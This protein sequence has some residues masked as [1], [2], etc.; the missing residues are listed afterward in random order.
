VESNYVDFATIMIYLFWFFFFGLIVY[1]RME[2]KRE[3]YPLV[4]DRKSVMV[5]GWPA[6]PAPKEERAKHSAL[7]IWEARNAAAPVPPAAP[8]APVEPAPITPPQEEA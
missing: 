3:G 2:D 6:A 5:Q 8:A 7:H 4:S 1:L